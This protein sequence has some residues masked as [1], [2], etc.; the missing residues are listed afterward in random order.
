MKK[1]VTLIIL[2]M[3]G[4]FTNPL[5]QADAE[6]MHN[7]KDMDPADSKVMEEHEQAETMHNMKDMYPADSKVMDRPGK[8][9]HQVTIN[10]YTLMYHMMNLS[11]RNEMVEMM[12]SSSDIG[13]NRSPDVTNHLMVYIMDSERKIVPG[14]VLFHLTNPDGKDSRTMTMGMYG[15]YGGDI[16]LEQKGMHTIRTRIIIETAKTIRL[17]DEFTYE[18]K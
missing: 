2:L 7:M 12:K 6:T 18:V 10:G 14:T 5:L 16:I 1:I 8:H 13:I 11:E 9:I 17:D 15:G 4:V 3:I